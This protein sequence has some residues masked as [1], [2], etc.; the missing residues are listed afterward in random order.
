MKLRMNGKTIYVAALA[1]L[2]SACA[3]QRTRSLQQVPTAQAEQM[4]AQ[5]EQSLRM[6]KQWGF[7]GRVAVSNGKDGG[8]GRIDWRQNG[9][10]YSVQLSAPITRQS[11]KLSIV[12][13]EATLDGL[14]GGVR[15]GR[16]AGLLVQQATGWEIPLASLS[17]WV[18]GLRGKDAQSVQYDAQG[19]LAHMQQAGWSIDYLWPQ[20]AGDNALPR[21]IDAVKGQAKVKLLVDQ[22]QAG[23]GQ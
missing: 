14:E 23:A 3:A 2:L 7:S 21:R 11:W 4:Q 9:A 10:D 16:D 18:R 5:R 6:Q 1:L 15:H 8:S 19:R 17:D 20:E 13:G 12:R 22:W